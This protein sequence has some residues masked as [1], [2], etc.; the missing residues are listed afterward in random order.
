MR[1]PLSASRGLNASNFWW[2]VNTFAE[3]LFF[4]SVRA[5]GET[6]HLFVRAADNPGPYN[7][8]AEAPFLRIQDAINAAP[9][10][11]DSLGV[12]YIHVC[13]GFV[14]SQNLSVENSFS[15]TQTWVSAWVGFG[16]PVLTSLCALLSSFQLQYPENLVVDR[17]IFIRGCSHQRPRRHE[18]CAASSQALENIY[19]RSDS[20]ITTEKL[21][22]LKID[23]LKITFTNLTT[24]HSINTFILN[25]ARLLCFPSCS[26]S[27][28]GYIASL[29]H[30]RFVN[31]HHRISRNHLFLPLFL[32]LFGF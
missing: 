28:N 23:Q 25:F 24:Q 12:T 22:D 3:S 6:V 4:Y 2:L 26:I 30:M 8:T 27:F 32:I 21:I 1:N 9:K 13:A 14:R 7:G 31:F 20:I 16:L 17:S 5:L 29:F 18:D 15:S 19:I 10:N 11:L